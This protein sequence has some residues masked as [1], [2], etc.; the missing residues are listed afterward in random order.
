LIFGP[1][2]LHL[3]SPWCHVR[4]MG[5]IGTIVASLSKFWATFYDCECIF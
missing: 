3:A 5:S 1:C 4:Q 2:G